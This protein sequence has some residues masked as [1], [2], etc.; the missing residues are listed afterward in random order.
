M[1]GGRDEGDTAGEV[2]VEGEGFTEG[3]VEEGGGE[4]G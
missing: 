4:G 2:G 3:E 1:G